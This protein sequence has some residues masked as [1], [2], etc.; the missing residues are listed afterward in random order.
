MKNDENDNK[1]GI[2]SPKLE[3]KDCQIMAKESV[4]FGPSESNTTLEKL[5]RL[6]IARKGRCE[7]EDEE[8]EELMN[9]T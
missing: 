8:L 9:M 5:C 1:I 7:K 6:E 4:G 2:Y 3:G